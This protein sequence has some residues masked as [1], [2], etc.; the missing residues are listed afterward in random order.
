VFGWV[1]C[2]SLRRI[3]AIPVVGPRSSPVAEN[4][5]GAIPP[6]GTASPLPRCIL[7]D[8]R[9]AISADLCR[10]ADKQ[11]AG[12]AEPGAR[13]RARI[14]AILDKPRRVRPSGH[15]RFDSGFDFRFRCLR[16]SLRETGA[17]SSL[18]SRMP[19]T[20]ARYT[21]FRTGGTQVSGQISGLRTAGECKRAN[22]A[23]RNEPAG[24]IS[25]DEVV[26]A[27]DRRVRAFAVRFD[28]S[29]ET[30]LKRGSAARNW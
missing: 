20:A 1:Y 12:N 30:D 29:F 2:T 13:A 16:R 24:A 6:S 10:R 3:S 27:R 25:R 4:G 18:D 14:R 23:R 17:D 15:R 21:N 8:G 9:Y 11:D 19:A 5:V 28:E 26:P 7:I 22:G